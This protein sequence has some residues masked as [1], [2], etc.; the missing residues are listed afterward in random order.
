MKKKI[1]TKTILKI[2]L[3]KKYRQNKVYESKSKYNGN[4]T[5][6]ITQTNSNGEI[7]DYAVLYG[8]KNE[9]IFLGFQIECY[10]PDTFINPNI[11]ERDSIKKILS[12]ILLN[13]IK[14]F[15]CLIKEWHYYLIYYYNKDD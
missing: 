5:F 15:N 8:K 11:L 6:C 1:K 14:L 3:N 7:L 4:E 12:P 13:S 2:P 9:K 10:S